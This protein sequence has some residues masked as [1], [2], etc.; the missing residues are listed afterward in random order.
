MVNHIVVVKSELSREDPE[1]VRELYRMLKE[2]RAASSEPPPKDG[3]DRN[4]IGWS[5]N[6]RNFEVAAQYA[7]QQRLLARP[8]GL[9]DLFDATTRALD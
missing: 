4:P 3:I 9:E 2:S 1:A 8:L 7:W 5:A 6:R